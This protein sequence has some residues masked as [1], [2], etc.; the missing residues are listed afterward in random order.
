MYSTLG[1]RN[2]GE[3]LPGYGL[4]NISAK[5][6]DEAWNVTFYVNNL[7]DKYAFTSASRNWGDIEFGNRGSD[8]QRSYAHYIL[9]PR[10][11]GLKFS[12]Q[13]GM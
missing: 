7:F 8:L 11:V 13:F 12:Y 3:E 4:S 6:S 9:T 1:L 2:Y 5:L 10:T